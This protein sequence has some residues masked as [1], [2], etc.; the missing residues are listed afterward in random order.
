MPVIGEGSP[1]RRK[2]REGDRHARKSTE[3]EHEEEEEEKGD[4]VTS[5]VED[6]CA[7]TL[8]AF[9]SSAPTRLKHRDD[10]KARVAMRR[11]RHREQEVIPLR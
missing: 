8:R 4:V 6:A 9:G 5:I 10:V 7:P 3:R 1:R 11:D 2:E